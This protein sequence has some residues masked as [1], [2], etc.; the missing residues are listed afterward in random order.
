LVQQRQ[1]YFC[2]QLIGFPLSVIGSGCPTEMDKPK[3]LAKA[4]E[5]GFLQSKEQVPIKF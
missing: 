4:T 5:T 2:Y 1:A 3:T